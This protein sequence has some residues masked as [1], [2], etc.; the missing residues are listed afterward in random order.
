VHHCTSKNKTDKRWWVFVCLCSLSFIHF[1]SMHFCVFLLCVCDFCILWL[2]VE[3]NWIELNWIER[4]MNEQLTFNVLY[5]FV[6]IDW[7]IDIYDILLLLVYEIVAQCEP[8]KDKDVFDV[9]VRIRSV[10]C[11]LY[12]VV[13][14]DVREMTERVY[15]SFTHPLIH[16][17]PSL[18]F[19]IWTH[20]TPHTLH[21]YTTEMKDWHQR[22]LENVQRNL[23]NWWKCVGT[24][25]PINVLYPLSLNLLKLC[26]FWFVKLT[27]THTYWREVKWVSLS[28]L[29]LLLC[30]LICETHSR[31]KHTQIQRA[32]K[33]F[34]QCCNN[35]GEIE[36]EHTVSF[37]LFFIFV[38]SHSLLPLSLFLHYLN[39]FS[40]SCSCSCNG[41]WIKMLV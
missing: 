2:N 14:W 32:L 37:I 40:R 25:I 24:K 26:L 28:V 4:E 20:L 38:C 39:I 15:V 11:A 21:T 35:S 5:T 36:S 31:A 19:L 27:L 7:L 3:L 30:S 10:L 17:S 9:G 29:C 41:S 16:I 22:F 12:C 13:C 8:H 1:F 18:W 6:C 34:V 23:H 33:R